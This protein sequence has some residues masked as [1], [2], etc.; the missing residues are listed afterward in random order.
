MPTR[1]PR[2]SYGLWLLF[3]AFLIGLGLAIFNYLWTGN[4]IHGTPGALLVI[5]STGL[6]CI[7]CLALAEW[8][9]L[10]GWLRLLLLF[11][12]VMDIVAT[13]LAA[14]MLAAY[15]L[16]AAMAISAVG[17]ALHVGLDPPSSRP[18]G[19]FVRS[20]REA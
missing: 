20:N 8:P 10:P 19:G 13:G 5:I 15:W 7:T 16:V 1:A 4:G 18:S 9:G 17:W 11:L 14:Y 3:A 12:I 2:F 6:A